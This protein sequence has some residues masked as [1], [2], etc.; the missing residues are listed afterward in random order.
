MS[1]GHDNGVNRIATGDGGRETGARGAPS[2]QLPPPNPGPRSGPRARRALNWWTQRWIEALEA[3]GW[4]ARLKRGRTYARSGRV[5]SIDIQP[6]RVTALVR[7]SRPQ[8]YRVRI[9]L[10]PLSDEVWQRVADLLARQ[11]RFAAS[12]LAGEMPLTIDDAFA[13]AG[14]RLFPQPS[15]KLVTDCSCPDWAN[16]CKH[17]AAVHYVL[18][19]E[20]DGDP[21]LLFRLRGRSKK[22]FMADLRARRAKADRASTTDEALRPEAEVE[23]DQADRPL[24]ASPDRFWTLGDEFDE[25]RFTIEAPPVPEAVVKRLGSPL[26]GREGELAEAELARL[27]RLISERAI[28]LAY[29]ES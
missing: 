13:S 24:M 2:S 29:E 6:G 12:L 11:A 27:Y 21:F 25:L 18:G 15:E 16:P 20:F 3:F 28:K 10:P 14:A 17:I 1:E 22:T 23:V 9:E 26:A 19:R 5:Q 4:E 7:G 8:P